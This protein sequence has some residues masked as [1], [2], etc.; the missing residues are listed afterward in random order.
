[1]DKW[2]EIQYRLWANNRGRLTV[3]RGNLQSASDQGGYRAT[4][5]TWHDALLLTSIPHLEPFFNAGHFPALRLGSRF[6][7]PLRPRLLQDHLERMLH[8]IQSRSLLPQTRGSSFLVQASSVAEAQ[9]SAL[10]NPCL[11]PEPSSCPPNWPHIP[12]KVLPLSNFA[13]STEYF[14][15]SCKPV[16]L[17]DASFE[18]QVEHE[19]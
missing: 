4:K 8:I 14:Q 16:E 7:S 5:K 3:G 17:F 10:I 15:E 13:E 9:L 6:G 19:T 2:E 1:M 11:Q 12:A 18:H